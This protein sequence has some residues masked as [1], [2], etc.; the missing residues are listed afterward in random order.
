MVRSPTFWLLW[1]VG[2][3]IAFNLPFVS[4]LMNGL[5]GLLASITGV[6]G[7]MAI[8]AFLPLIG[9]LAMS[10]SRRSRS[11]TSS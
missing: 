5:V 11:V 1:F 4:P 8:V 6:A 10:F 3:V 9:L 2:I 7:A